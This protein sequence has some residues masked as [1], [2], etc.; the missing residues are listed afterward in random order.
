LE[1]EDKPLAKGKDRYWTDQLRGIAQEIS[2]L[3]IACDIDITQSGISK[4]ILDND[5]S[6]CRKKNSVAFGKLKSHLMVLYPLEEKAIE[7]M[8]PDETKSIIEEVWGE[9]LEL[10]SSGGS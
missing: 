7:R 1:D 9:V 6:V 5:E 2:K 10:R 8:G 3:A 4:R